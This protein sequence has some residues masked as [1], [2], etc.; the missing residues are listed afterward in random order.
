MP[1][2]SGRVPLSSG[3]QKRVP[4]GAGVTAAAEI[5]SLPSARQTHQASGN[6]VAASGLKAGE[7][8]EPHRAGHPINT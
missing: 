7:G 1:A 2:A 3:S 8:A 4:C 6:Q 5:S